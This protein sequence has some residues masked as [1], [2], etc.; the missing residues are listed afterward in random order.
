MNRSYL[1]RLKTPDSD[2]ILDELTTRQHLF[3]HH[4]L[5]R[6]LAESAAEIGFCP[7]A[8]ERAVAWLQ[9]DGNAAIGRLRRTELAQLARCV[10]R[11][12]RQSLAGEP[13]AAPAPQPA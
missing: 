2:E 9:L 1:R 8:A 3:P 6:V 7:A 5:S 4:A 10:Y 12:W 11:F 13:A